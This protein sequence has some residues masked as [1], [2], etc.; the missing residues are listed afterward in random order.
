[1]SSAHLTGIPK[2]FQKWLIA[3]LWVGWRCWKVAEWL[4]VP[5]RPS[6]T[7]GRIDSVEL[8]LGA[9]AEGDGTNWSLRV[10]DAVD[11]PAEPSEKKRE[12][13]ELK[14]VVRRSSRNL[15]P[16]RV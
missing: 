1:M 4:A 15:A 14:L 3:I 11:E 9:R 8:Q 2:R 13:V 7:T 10:Y 12:R 6:P 16:P 5:V